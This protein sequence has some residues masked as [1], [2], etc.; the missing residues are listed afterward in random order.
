ML[1]FFK[2][3]NVQVRITRF[4]RFLLDKGVKAEIRL[5]KITIQRSS[6]QLCLQKW[7]ICRSI[8]T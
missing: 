1:I 2:H 3:Y 5:A 6:I 8:Q 4:Y 7:C